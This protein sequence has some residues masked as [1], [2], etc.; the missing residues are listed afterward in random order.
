[1]EQFRIKHEFT[2]QNLDFPSECR[3][4]AS[5]QIIFE[6]VF[7]N[8]QSDVVEQLCFS[9]AMFSMMEEPLFLPFKKA[10][11]QPSISSRT[12]FLVAKSSSS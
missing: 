1:V 4:S 10:L 12:P 7:T 11:P 9:A 8:R 2:N 6:K 3:T 5:G